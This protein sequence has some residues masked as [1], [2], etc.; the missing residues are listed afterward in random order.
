METET[1][2]FI[3]QPKRL[4]RENFLVSS[5]TPDRLSELEL[6]DL[7]NTNIGDLF[8]QHGIARVWALDLWGFI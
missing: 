6:H 8:I 4:E 5:A 3:G 1:R 7:E 2:H